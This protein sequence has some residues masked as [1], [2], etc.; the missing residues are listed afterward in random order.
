[1]NS[2]KI[3]VIM[4]ALN[5]ENNVAKAV[6][7]AVDSFVRTEVSGE[8]VII[9]DG[10]TDRTKD[11]A[12]RLIKR[13]PFIRLINHS[14]PKGI[15]AS[16]W[17][18]VK[19]SRGEVVTMLPGDGEN[20]AYE[21]LRY[22]PVMEHV[23]IVIPFVYNNYVRSL[24][25]RI[26]SKLYKAIINISFGMLLNYM[27]GTVMYRKCILDGID[28]KANGFFYQT[29]LLIKC[30]KNRYIYAEVPYGLKKRD[31]GKS[32]ALTLKSLLEVM[33]GYL[34]VMAAIYLS[35]KDERHIAFDSVTAAR[36]RQMDDHEE[37][38]PTVLSKQA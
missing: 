35:N 3:S 16:F 26:I 25:R 21:I 6:E 28:L 27:N 4:P 15:G 11:V 30:L 14:Q 2:Y 10:S 29:E 20:D 34:S 1:M 32:K 31:G 12:E 37:G 9:N 13:H 38:F 23:D 7:D 5:E 24:K 8:I 18:G 33:K 17:E 22:L 36:K 19:E